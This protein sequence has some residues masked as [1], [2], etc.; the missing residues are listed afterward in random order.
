MIPDLICTYK[1]DSSVSHVVCIPA[2]GEESLVPVMRSLN[3]QT[4]Q[5]K[6]GVSICINASEESAPEIWET[7]LK[8]FREAEKLLQSGAFE[9]P[10]CMELHQK[11][12]ARKAGVGL[13]RKLAMDR[14][15]DWTNGR[16]DTLLFCLDADCLVAENYI[17]KVSE[18]FHLYIQIKAASVYFEHRPGDDA[19]LNEGIA[20]YELHLRALKQGLQWSGYPW[21]FHTVGS[22]M[23]VRAETYLKSGGMN[24]RQAG[25]DFY[26]LHKLMPLGFG[27]INDTCVYPATRLSERVP[28][29]TGR[30]MHQYRE[31]RIQYSYHPGIFAE[32]RILFVHL[33]FE[34]ATW[35]RDI[36]EELKSILLSEG[37]E[38]AIGEAAA[39]S[40]NA[41]MAVIRLKKWFS[42]FRIIRI[43]HELRDRKYPDLEVT[44]A[45]KLQLEMRGIP[46]TEDL[47]DLFRKL[48]RAV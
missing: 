28:F 12:P 22:S 44:R 26:F 36:S 31:Q 8:A 16:A 20:L 27:E 45:A 1:Y 42:G 38:A 34:P 35:K 43:M 37:I 10:V 14:A 23:V 2:S 24:T 5:I 47:P 4:G 25:E 11:L 17:Q 48:D 46:G 33:F 29:G 15:C 18:Y 9:F 30:S 7:N 13:A 19:L 39:H 6:F 40:R 32:L 21:Y 41:E 3:K